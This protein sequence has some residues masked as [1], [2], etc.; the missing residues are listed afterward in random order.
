[1]LPDT[2]A[3]IQRSK[4]LAAL[5]LILSPEWEFRY[6]SFNSKWSPT[7]QMASM[8]NGSGDDWFMV[9][10]NSGWVALKGLDHESPAWGEGREPLAKALQAVFPAE[11]SSFVEEPAF[12]MDYASFAG[13]RLSPG[14]P[15][16]RANDL[17][18]FA[19]LE[20][21]ERCLVALLSGS[22]ADYVEHA[23]EYFECEID[24]AIVSRIFALEPISE[25]M[26]EALNP[27]VKLPEIAEELFEE[28]GY[29]R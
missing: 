2:P 8:R 26:V 3:L 10:H 12:A 17:T 21:G 19:L 22:A 5:D 16:I 28:I 9:F 13:Y 6:Y 18:P 15:W 25:E 11:L 23:Q 1:M 24:A 20:S 7:E 29:P 14:T 27:E 4:A